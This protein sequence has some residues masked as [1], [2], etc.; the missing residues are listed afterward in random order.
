MGVEDRLPGTGASPVN[1]ADE[2]FGLR[3]AVRGTG[4]IKFDNIGALSN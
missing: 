3:C 1:F 4:H 2:R